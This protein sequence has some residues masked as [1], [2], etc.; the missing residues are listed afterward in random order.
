MNCKHK[1]YKVIKTHGNKSP[2]YVVC[3]NCNKL[4]NFEDIKDARRRTKNK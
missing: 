4:L 1:R 2:G 3:K